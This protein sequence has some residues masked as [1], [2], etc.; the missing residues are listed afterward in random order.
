MKIYH[1]CIDIYYINTLEWRIS[2]GSIFTCVAVRANLETSK[3]KGRIL[4]PK[5]G[6]WGLYPRHI[7]FQRLF[8]FLRPGTF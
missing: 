5:H 6:V 7:E 2:V 4:K 3:K 1:Y 8:S